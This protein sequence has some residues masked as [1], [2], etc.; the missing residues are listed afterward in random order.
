M[1][2]KTEGEI[3]AFVRTLWPKCELDDLVIDSDDEVS[4][5]VVE[6]E[7]V[8]LRFSDL[9]A[10]SEFFGTKR[11]DV[12]SISR[13]GGCPTCDYGETRGFWINVRRE[14]N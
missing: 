10:L 1:N 5:E 8:N 6:D 14:E 2:A 3:R 9:F 11:I 13:H 4:F 7:G 12:D